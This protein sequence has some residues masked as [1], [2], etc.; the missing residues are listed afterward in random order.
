MPRINQ[1][2][3]SGGSA[4]ERWCRA[5]IPSFAYLFASWVRVF[6]LRAFACA[7]GFTSCDSHHADSKVV[8]VCLFIAIK[9]TEAMHCRQDGTVWLLFIACSL[10]Y[11]LSVST[12]GGQPI[13]KYNERYCLPAVDTLPAVN[14]F[15]ADL[16]DFLSA[17]ARLLEHEL[18]RGRNVRLRELLRPARRRPNGDAVAV[19]RLGLG[20]R[21][22]VQQL[23]DAQRLFRRL[24]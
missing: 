8:V 10:A 20:G 21:E 14:T 18:L 15:M 1:Q 5:R 3:S 11:Y 2:R 16:H 23:G 19:L 12:A 17:H 22:V 4:K 9:A 7:N 6:R 24:E 13:I